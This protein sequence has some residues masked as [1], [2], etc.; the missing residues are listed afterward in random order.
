MAT[1]RCPVK[2]RV[3]K[4][5]PC[6]GHSMKGQRKG[7]GKDRG[8]ERTGSPRADDVSSLYIFGFRSRV[9][10]IPFIKLGHY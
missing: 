6:C 10:S 3:E 9:N 1:L 2:G 5:S 4:K 8:L 7:T